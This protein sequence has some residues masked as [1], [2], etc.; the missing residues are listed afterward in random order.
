MVFSNRFDI[1]Q[2]STNG[3][4]Y[5]AIITDARSA[6][7]VALDVDKGMVYWADNVN[8][9]ICRT[10]KNGDGK[11]EVLVDTGIDKPEGLALDWIAKKLYWSDSR[12]CI[13]TRSM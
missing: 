10:A 13:L 5:K 12:K 8:K 1:R 9:T 7:A 11:V 4:D 3:H 6:V 2:I